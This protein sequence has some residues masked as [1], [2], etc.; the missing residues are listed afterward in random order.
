MRDDLMHLRKAKLT[1]IGGSGLGNSSKVM[2]VSESALGGRKTSGT[3]GTGQQDWTAVDEL[4]R[5]A[6][7][8]MTMISLL[9]LPLD[10]PSNAPA[11]ADGL[12]SFMSGL[13]EYLSRCLYFDAFARHWKLTSKPRPDV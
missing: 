1:G 13:P 8:S 10:L 12:T 4:S 3:G 5:G 7:C 2:E 11:S 6:Y 9:G